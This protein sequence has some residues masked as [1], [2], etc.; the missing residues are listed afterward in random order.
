MCQ[1]GP[2]II[3]GYVESRFGRLK[4]HFMHFALE[5]M[6]RIFSSLF[7]LLSDNLDTIVPL[8]TRNQ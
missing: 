8:V 2:A 7:S 6:P 4:K 3:R 5:G 1:T